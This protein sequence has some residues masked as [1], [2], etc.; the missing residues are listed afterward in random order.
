MSQKVAHVT[1]VTH[2]TH[3]AQE[4]KSLPHA[5]KSVSLLLC[6]VNMFASFAHAYICQLLHNL[7]YGPAFVARCVTTAI[8]RDVPR[9]ALDRVQL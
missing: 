9:I 7:V 6:C 2:V 8:F 3:V 1:R 4:S 5:Y